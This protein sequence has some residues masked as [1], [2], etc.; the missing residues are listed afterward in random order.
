MNRK[1]YPLVFRPIATPKPWGGAALANVLG[2]HFPEIPENEKIG[3]SWEL[4]D[5][6]ENNTVVSNGWLA[7][8]TLGSLMKEYKERIAGNRVYGRYGSQFP[9]LIKFLDIE[10]KL[11]VQVHPDDRVAAERYGSLGKAEAWYIL[12]AQPD[13]KIYMGLGKDVEQA[14]FYEACGKGTADNLLNV[15]HPEKGDVIFI[16]PGTVHAADGG[17]LVCEIQESSDITFRLY[18]WGRELNPATARRMHLDEASGLINLRKYDGSGFLK[19]GPSPSV[20][21]SS[22]IVSCPQFKISRITL[23][24]TV[25]KDTNGGFIVYCCIKGEVSIRYDSS[26]EAGEYSLKSGDTCLIPADM[27]EF[28]LVPVEKGSEVLESVSYSEQS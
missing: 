11:S 12:D 24:D 4:A 8:R 7:G 3:E 27:P 22:R 19:A 13:A 18:D 23:H 1:L 28:S 16:N 15:I 9:L 21:T 5:M 6:G 10:D 26:D 20:T 25:K 2:K 14:E 17:I